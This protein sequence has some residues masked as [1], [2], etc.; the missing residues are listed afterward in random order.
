MTLSR[1]WKA[2]LCLCAAARYSAAARHSPSSTASFARSAHSFLSSSFPSLG[3]AAVFA[4]CAAPLPPPP[5]TTADIPPGAD[6]ITPEV[7]LLVLLVVVAMAEDGLAAEEGRPV[8]P[9]CGAAMPSSS[10]CRRI[11]STSAPLRAASS[12]VMPRGP[13]ADAAR[14]AAWWHLSYCVVKLMSF[15]FVGWCE[16]RDGKGEGFCFSTVGR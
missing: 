2:S 15:V 4:R 5:L 16:R 3:T 6:R 1:S 13:A 7:F 14:S 12:M 8:P 10:L 11:L 9:V